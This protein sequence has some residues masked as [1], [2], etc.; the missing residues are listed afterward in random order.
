MRALPRLLL[1]AALVAPVLGLLPSGTAG[2]AGCPA[3]G[4]RAIAPAS[5]SGDVVFRGGG[6]GHGLGMSQYGAQG[7]ARLGC[8]AEE[9][10]TRYYAGTRVLP[11]AMPA[12]IR[13]RMLDN[14]YRVDVEAVQGTLAWVR[15][16]LC[17]RGQRRPRRPRR[18]RRRAARL[19]HPWSPARR[20]RR[21]S[22]RA[23]AGSCGSTTRP[24]A[25]S[26]STTSGSCPRGCSGRAARRRRRSPLHRGRRGGPPHHLARVVDLPG[27][28]GCAGT[29]RC[30]P[31]PAASRRRAAHREHRRRAGDGQVPLG[32]RRGAGV[33]PGRR[34]AGPGDRRAHLRGQAGR[35]RPD[36]DP[37]RPE[38]DRLGEG[39]RGH[40]TAP[41]AR[42]GRRPSTRPP[43]RSW[44][45]PTRAR[46]STRSTPR[47]WA[48][49]PRTSA[50][51][52]AS[53]RRS[54][55][56]STTRRGT[57]RRA[58]RPPSGPGPA[59]SPG[60]PWPP[61]SAS[62]A[63]AR[64]RCRRAGTDA[65]VAGVKVVGIRSGV[66][67]DVVRRGLGRATGARP[68]LAGL[69]DL[70]ADASA[71]RPPS[72]WSATGTATARTS[73]AGSRTARWPC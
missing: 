25:S 5:A 7:A 12:G 58:T 3:S 19:P 66:A 56:P 1:T 14:G 46:R 36:A 17:R 27:P 62:P 13:L 50:T 64:S 55:A 54:C 9:I 16:R 42:P 32:H 69:H 61:G 2:A 18:P 23:R 24:T 71:A 30:S 68:A 4:G 49:T 44:S 51:S 22:R 70:G 37:G 47:R 21:R 73:P 60:R 6:W 29:G 35:P 67:H 34:P 15:G 40:R 59:A 11:A 10:L 8:S 48:A 72:R 63:S 38:L 39:D 65:R 28:R 41:G 53:S 20:A 52:G 57:P 26:P 33:L 31:S 43:A 45:R